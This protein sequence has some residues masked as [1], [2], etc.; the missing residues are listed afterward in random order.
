[1]VDS[2]NQD[3]LLC[4]FNQCMMGETTDSKN[5]VLGISRLEQDEWAVASHERAISAT[6]AGVFHGEIVP[7][8]VPQRRG[9]PL[10]VERDE[11][12]RPGT[13]V[14]TLAKLS[15]AF[16]ADG[17]VTAGNASQISDGAV[18]VIVAD[19]DAVTL[20]KRPACQSWPRSSVTARRPDPT[21]RCT[22]VPLRPS[23][24]LLPQPE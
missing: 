22:S 20:P 12:M 7:V 2:L 6:D 8:E 17:T 18:A 1:L 9:D 21:P 23:T 5:A 13:T 15:P 19:R 4:A 14:E 3:G 10:V 11:G 24:R 16:L